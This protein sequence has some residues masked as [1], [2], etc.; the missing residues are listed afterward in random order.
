MHTNTVYAYLGFIPTTSVVEFP[1]AGRVAGFGMRVERLE[2]KCRKERVELAQKC[3]R[4]F[5]ARLFQ[6][7]RVA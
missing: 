6:N 2:P 3:D 1:Q 7:G 4:S 5:S